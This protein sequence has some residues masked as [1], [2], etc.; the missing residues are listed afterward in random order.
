MSKVVTFPCKMESREW[1]NLV[2]RRTKCLGVLTEMAPPE[3]LQEI[4]E[5]ENV[6]ATLWKQLESHCRNPTKFPP[7]PTGNLTQRW[8]TKVAIPLTLATQMLE[9]GGGET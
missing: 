5:I 8:I 9:E 7:P 4:A 1:S 6:L 3:T 2:D